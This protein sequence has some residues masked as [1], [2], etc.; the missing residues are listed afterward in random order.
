ML[1][2]IKFSTLVF[3]C[4]FS[5]TVLQAQ[6]Y[7]ILVLPSGGATSIISAALLQYL[8]HQT[9]IPTN[10]LFNEIW[11]SSAGAIIAALLTTSPSHKKNAKQVVKFIKNNFSTYRKAYHICDTLL[12]KIGPDYLINKTS[13]PIRILTAASKN[14]S[15]MKWKLYDFTSDGSGSCTNSHVPVA[16][17]VKGSCTVYPYL[18]RSAKKI[19]INKKEFIYCIDPGSLCCKPSVIDPTAYFLKQFLPRLTQDDTLTIYFLGN[20]FTQSIDYENIDKILQKFGKKYSYAIRY[21]DGTFCENMREQIEIVNI[22]VTTHCAEILEKY[23]KNATFRMKFKIRI[24][25]LIFEKVLGKENAVPNL[26]ATGTIPLSVL[27]EEAQNIIQHSKNFQAMLGVL[28][29]NGVI[30]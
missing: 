22:P 1:Q 7:R 11:C 8:E 12:Q 15:Q 29:R 24:L 20:A 18:Y 19:C 5:C 9:D 13:I 4:F 26:L 10:K 2:Q 27:T 21:H 30:C 14:P 6:D 3:A 28:K 23:V 17:I 16:D 25:K